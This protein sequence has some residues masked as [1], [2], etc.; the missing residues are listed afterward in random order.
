MIMSEKHI[1]D[2]DNGD[3]SKDDREKITNSMTE[4][5]LTLDN[6]KNHRYLHITFIRFA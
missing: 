5:F 3:C 1:Y 2:D 4:F 6:N